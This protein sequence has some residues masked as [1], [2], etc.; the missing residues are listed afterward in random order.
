MQG[1]Q[2]LIAFAGA[3]RHGGF[4]AAAREAGTAPSTIAKSVAR[5]EK[6]LGVRLFHRTTR[7]MRLTPD[8][9]RL[10]ER[11]QRVLAELEDLQAEASGARA[12]L[13]G[14]LRVS[15]PVLYGTRFVMPVLAELC[16]RHPALQLDI[17]LTDERV[18]LIREGVDLAVRIGELRDSSLVA[19]RIDQQQLVLCASATYLKRR[20]TPARIE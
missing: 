19:R 3:A 9:E 7:Q 15:L 14:M 2:Q 20:G 16:L 6:D 10:Y 1:L 17:S 13:S 18:D 4:A 12:A 11:C 5:L 8:G